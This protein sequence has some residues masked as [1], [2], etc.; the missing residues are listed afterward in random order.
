MSRSDL[1]IHK[2][3]QV[4]ASFMALKLFSQHSAQVAFVEKSV[5]TPTRPAFESTDKLRC[6]VDPSTD[7]RITKPCF[8]TNTEDK[9]PILG[10]TNVVYKLSCHACSSPYVGKAD[11]ALSL[12]T[13]EHAHLKYSA[14]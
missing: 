3:R 1:I 7:I 4:S 5:W 12:H 14:V 10:K 8:V 2:L 6:L 9:P 13:Y 11:R